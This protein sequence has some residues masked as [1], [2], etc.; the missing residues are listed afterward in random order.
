MSTNAMAIR[1]AIISVLLFCAVAVG[2]EPAATT[3]SNAHN[4]GATPTPIPL[5]TPHP[6]PL[7]PIT[8]TNTNDSGPG[9]LRQALA[10]AG[11]GD[12]I[13]FATALDGQTV[14][15][16]SAELAI[17]K[18]VT[19]D[20]PG[21]DALAVS[22]SPGT[23][24]RIFHVM[25]GHTV[26]IRGLTITGGGLDDFGGGILNDHATLTVSYCTVDLNGALGGGGI[27][28]DGSNGSA[29]LTVVNSTVSGNVASSVGGIANDFGDAGSATLIVLNST[30]SDNVAAYGS[31][32]GIANSSVASISNST[33]SGNSAPQLGGGIFNL[34]TLTI[35]NSTISGN[36]VGSTMNGLKLGGGVC[37]LSGTLTIVNSTFSGNGAFGNDLKG[38]GLGGAIY[39]GPFE[40]GFG[41]VTT[42]TLR[43]STLS[44]NQA[45]H[46]GGMYNDQGPD[47]TSLVEISNTILSAGFSG[48]NIFNSGGTITSDGY[49][50]CSD[51]GS[52]LLNGPGDQVDTDPLLGPLQDNGGP[53]F[54]HALL[55][56]SPAIDAGDPNFTP[57]PYYDQRGPRFIR[58]FNGR[59]DVGSV[60]TQPP[61]SPFPTPRP[62]PTPAP[63]PTPH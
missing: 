21:P 10:D 44:D 1:F 40:S 61:P 2:A 57:P 26:T 23:P 12:N 59:I 39:T 16:T 25:P 9:S 15:L 33:I 18:N 45:N 53:T 17:D 24:L 8:V 54:T 32:G 14:T 50:V 58:V 6:R 20:G 63:R 22:R 11:D 38:P 3:S 46:G 37:N 19:I 60:E 7:P 49:N 4:S 55:P 13:T 31:V 41:A 42:L 28:N 5:P 29:T 43:N 30:V 56:G 47:T 35:V 36:T 34:G 62:R 51:D 48:E 27:Y 52:G